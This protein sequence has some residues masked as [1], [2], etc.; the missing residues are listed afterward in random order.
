MHK[1]QIQFLIYI[2]KTIDKRLDFKIKELRLKGTESPFLAFY[3]NNL[4]CYK[5][6][7]VKELNKNK[8]S[9]LT[10]EEFTNFIKQDTFF[11]KYSYQDK[12]NNGFYYFK[13]NLKGYNILNLFDILK[14]SNLELI[15]ANIDNMNYT[16]EALAVNLDINKTLLKKDNNLISV[17]ILSV[18][19]IPKELSYMKY[20]LCYFNDRDTILDIIFLKKIS[21]KQIHDNINY[22]LQE[23]NRNK[24]KIKITIHKLW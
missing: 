15:K 11:I 5:P 13:N 16:S 9:G 21:T 24:D 4:V 14:K 19:K 6:Q 23:D 20:T 22:L 3:R 18:R 10:A 12:Y 1:K 8:Y 7:V 17:D 2:R